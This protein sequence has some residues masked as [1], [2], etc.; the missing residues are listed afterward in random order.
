M[1][2]QVERP[3]ERKDVHQDE[4]NHGRHDKCHLQLV[5]AHPARCLVRGVGLHVI[6]ES[7][8]RRNHQLS[9][10]KFSENRA[11]PTDSQYVD[12]DS[13]FVN[14]VFFP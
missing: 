12:T 14:L 10:K 5:V 11:S 13:R 1:E 2:T 8:Q 7:H 4:Q 6:Y 3:E 9:E